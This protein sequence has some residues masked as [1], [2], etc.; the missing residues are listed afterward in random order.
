L[1]AS[2]LDH[3]NCQRFNRESRI[4]RSRTADFTSIILLT[5]NV[6]WVT[7]D[8]YGILGRRN[9]GEWVVWWLKPEDV[10]KP[11]AFRYL[12]GGGVTATIRASGIERATPVPN[13][14]KAQVKGGQ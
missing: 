5:H 8:R 12:F 2:S 6:Q 14:L 3:D 1:S 10:E 13:A 7:A 11:T 4:S 9:S